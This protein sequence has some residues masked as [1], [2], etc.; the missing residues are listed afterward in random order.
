ML[1]TFNLQLS[2]F[3]RMFR[4]WVGRKLVLELCF[5]D[6]LQCWRGEEALLLFDVSD[7]LFWSCVGVGELYF[8]IVHQN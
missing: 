4:G 2:V 6:A 7:L 5:I 1:A 3:V 8:L